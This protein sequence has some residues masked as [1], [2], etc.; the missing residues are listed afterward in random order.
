MNI[1]SNIKNLIWILDEKKT[2]KGKCPMSYREE[3]KEITKEC[4]LED[5]PEKTDADIQ[6]LKLFFLIFRLIFA[7]YF[8]LICFSNQLSNSFSDRPCAMLSY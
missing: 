8:A 4:L 6:G 3:N 7:K 2:V 5:L 1:I